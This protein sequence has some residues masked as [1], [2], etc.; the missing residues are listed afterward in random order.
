M[1]PGD[2]NYHA[3]CDISRSEWELDKEFTSVVAEIIMQFL[4]SDTTHYSKHSM[5]TVETFSYWTME[6]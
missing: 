5:H 4:Q 3:R 1:R 2:A 6:G